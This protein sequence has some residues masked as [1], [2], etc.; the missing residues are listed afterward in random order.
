MRPHPLLGKDALRDQIERLAHV[1]MFEIG[2][3]PSE[4]EGAVDC[5]IRLLRKAY[6]L[7]P[8]YLPTKGEGMN[9]QELL[10][11]KCPEC[12]STPPC[13]HKTDDSQDW[14]DLGTGERW[15]CDSCD[16]FRVIVAF[17]PEDEVT[18]PADTMVA[19]MSLF[20]RTIEALDSAD[21]DERYALRNEIQDFIDSLGGVPG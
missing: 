8:S 7:A 5:A 10:E 20:S 9:R 21:P 3:Q 19:A 6:V 16:A 11:A 17:D 18:V 1:I 15:H 2:R 12:G 13:W 14:G 4:S